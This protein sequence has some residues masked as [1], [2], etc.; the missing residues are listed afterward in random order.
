MFDGLQ[1]SAGK[2]GCETRSESRGLLGNKW[3]SKFLL[4]LEE[5]PSQTEPGKVLSSSECASVL[6]GPPGKWGRLG[7]TLL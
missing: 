6:P 4:S 2:G 5:G 3:A 7:T 1:A